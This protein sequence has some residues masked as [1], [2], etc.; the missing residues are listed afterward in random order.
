MFVARFP[1]GG[2]DRPVGGPGPP[3]LPRWLR[4]CRAERFISEVELLKV[5][6]CA[7]GVHTISP[8]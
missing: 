7:G 5:I 2:P 3:R 6:K 4:A 1:V 8:L